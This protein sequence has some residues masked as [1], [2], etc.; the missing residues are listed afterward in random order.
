MLPQVDEW[1][2]SPRIQKTLWDNPTDY[3][4]KNN[5]MDYNSRTT[6]LIPNKS[7]KYL[8]SHPRAASW[9]QI[10]SILIYYKSRKLNQDDIPK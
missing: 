5:F 4:T 2:H 10:M 9:G 3:N 6:L 7:P 8:A 1:R